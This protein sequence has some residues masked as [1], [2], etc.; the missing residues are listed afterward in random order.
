[1]S[2]LSL[3]N[4]DLVLAL[5]LMTV[6]LTV[7]C[8]A[9]S[10]LRRYA[11]LKN[12]ILLST[13][14]I[15]LA[16]PVALM[17]ARGSA[18]SIPMPLLHA[19]APPFPSVMEQADA[20]ELQRATSPQNSNATRPTETPARE[21]PAP[22][23][24][25]EESRASWSAA[26]WLLL[27]WAA[28]SAICLLRLTRSYLA[29]RFLLA[30]AQPADNPRLAAVA[31]QVG[32]SLGL[33][34]S[35]S[36]L[37]T[38]HV[39]SP[40]A[41]GTPRRGAV[42]IPPDTLDEMP[43]WQLVHVLTHETAHIAHRDSSLRLLQGIGAALWWWHPLIHLLNR[44]LSRTREEL[45]DN[46]VLSA[47]DPIEY[48]QTLLDIGRH[49][50]SHRPPALAVGLFPEHE[51]LEQR[52]RSLL[53]P[54]R[55]T[56][57]RSK[58]TVLLAMCL[59]GVTGSALAGA[60]RITTGESGVSIDTLWSTWADRTLVREYTLSV[61]DASQPGH[62]DIDIKRGDILV[63]AYDGEEI[64]VRLSVPTNG[65]EPE[66]RDGFHAF[67]GQPLD[68]EVR[69]NG[70]FIELDAN[71]Y[72]QITHI[73][74]LVPNRIDLTLDS[75]RTGVIQV[76]GV[77]GHIRARSQNNNIILSDVSGTA[78]VY[79]YNGSFTASFRDVTGELEF[80]SY[81]GDI[82]LT[83][84]TDFQSTMLIRSERNAVQSQFDIALRPAEA[85]ETEHE[86][87]SRSIDFGDAVVGDIA[88]GGPR[89][90]LE[91]TNGTVLL[92][93]P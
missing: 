51:R 72:E 62:L 21:L 18:W 48:G 42:I 79:G 70:N 13:L 1:M 65:A 81:N 77:E 22:A 12:S 10:F 52:I 93:K 88:G 45:C 2:L 15:T 43:D 4:N 41:F 84:P 58:P 27:I 86:N 50:T 6:V 78:D 24:A 36:V 85:V 23:H 91:T 75:Y 14:L 3:W 68:F 40:M 9:A 37:V 26:E 7:A 57:D 19:S 53:N 28:G 69:Q 89:T 35:P 61:E 82:D 44:Q 34:T 29:L 63:T 11:A 74:V 73:E 33:T 83:L 5:T 20:H 46:V 49:P 92:R 59:I 76:A 64:L 32:S 55:N 66:E 25:S 90:V 30:R 71:A 38:N 17:A 31:K 56:M 54:R 67:S 16:I 80:E 60:T 8:L 47:S 87:G 39:R